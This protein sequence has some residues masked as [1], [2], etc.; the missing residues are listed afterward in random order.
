[1]LFQLLIQPEFYGKAVSA[2]VQTPACGQRDAFL[3]Q[4]GNGFARVRRD[5]NAVKGNAEVVAHYLQFL[6][7][8]A[9]QPGKLSVAGKDVDPTF[10]RIWRLDAEFRNLIHDGS[11]RIRGKNI[12]PELSAGKTPAYVHHKADGLFS[13]FRAF[14]RKSENDVERWAN[15][16]RQASGR[17]FI[18][19]WEVLK[20]LV[21]G[22]PDFPGPR[23]RALAYL[24]E[25][26]FVQ[27]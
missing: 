4:P 3:R 8:A 2:M 5:G 19:G 26:T 15:P 14:S 23:F 13:L 10:Q 16:R 1:M 21:H 22:L 9:I 11:A 17:T 20:V 25:S 12:G 27:Q 7:I 18:D 6:M 24:V